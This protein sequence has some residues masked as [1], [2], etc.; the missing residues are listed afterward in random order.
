MNNKLIHF[1]ICI[2][3]IFI[4]FDDVLAQS[5][6]SNV[7]FKTINDNKIEITY[8]LSGYPSDTKFRVWV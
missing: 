7:N 2:L 3:I 5:K 1:L 8:Y 4:V 6:I